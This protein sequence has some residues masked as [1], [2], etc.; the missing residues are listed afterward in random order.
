M[1]CGKA[2]IYHHF[3]S[4]NDA[5]FRFLNYDHAKTSEELG[6]T[7]QDISRVPLCDSSVEIVILC[8]A[9]WGSK[10][11][12]YV[13]EAYRILETGGRLYL[14]EPTKRW[15]GKDENRVIIPG[16]E[17]KKLIRLVENTGFTIL[18]RDIQKFC[19]FVA[20]K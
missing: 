8:L 9:M 2:D 14:V 18:K 15:S 5:R 4:R 13:A 16:E 7:I 6:V 3:Q 17:A 10:K 1:G 20:I 11:K 19:F 12:E